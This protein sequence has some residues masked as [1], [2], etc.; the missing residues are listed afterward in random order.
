MTEFFEGSVGSGTFA[1]RRK[2]MH[3]SKRMSQAMANLRRQETSDDDVQEIEPRP[4]VGKRKRKPKEVVKVEDEDDDEVV[5]VE[6]ESSSGD[7]NLERMRG[8]CAA[9]VKR[10]NTGKPKPTKPRKQKATT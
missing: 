7:D 9:T 1:P 6:E 8:R 4:M 10:G 2:V 5:I 3:K